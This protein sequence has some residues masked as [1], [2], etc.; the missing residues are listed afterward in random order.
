[1]PRLRPIVLLL[2][3]AVVAQP[4]LAAGPGQPV[5]DMHVHAWPLELPPG[6]PACPG[7]QGVTLPPLD[8]AMR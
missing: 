4:A 8:P 1:M 6:T 2:F 3:L 5:I 7:D